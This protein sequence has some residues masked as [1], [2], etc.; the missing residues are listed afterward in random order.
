MLS[1]LAT[2]GNLA[3]ALRVAL[4]DF[5]SLYGAEMGDVQLAGRDG[6]LVIVEARGLSREFLET[7]RRVSASSGS[8]CGRAARDRAPIFI[9]DV[10]VDAEYAE[11]RDFAASVPFR[12]VLSCPLLAPTG[13]VRGMISGL[14]SHLLVPTRLEL[15]AAHAY[16]VEL[17]AV[18]GRVFGAADMPDW[19]EERSAAL[20]SATPRRGRQAVQAG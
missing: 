19:A 7:F 5:V 12:S 2:V 6:A 20:L 3:E 8:G 15:A 1:R 9:P 18:I 11:Y 16:C 10:S 17:S 4:R 13:E 14:S